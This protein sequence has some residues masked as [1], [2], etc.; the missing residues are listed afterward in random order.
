M[1]PLVSLE[2]CWGQI[3]WS[4]TLVCR[5]DVLF[6]LKLKRFLVSGQIM[7]ESIQECIR[8]LLLILQCDR[9]YQVS[10]CDLNVTSHYQSMTS[11]YRLQKAVVGDCLCILTE[12]SSHVRWLTFHSNCTCLDLPYGFNHLTTDFFR[13]PFMTKIFM[14]VFYSNRAL[15]SLT[16]YIQPWTTRDFVTLQMVTPSVGVVHWRL[17]FHLA[18]PTATRFQRSSTCEILP[19]WTKNIATLT[20]DIDVW[21]AK[22]CV[23]LLRLCSMEW[24][25]LLLYRQGV[26][27]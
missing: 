10:F 8:G 27:L 23:L 20:C 17:R 19:L 25:N 12:V 22:E 24:R 7:T 14:F 15:S 11:N 1:A 5:I 2:S 26:L 6:A 3:P 9:T 13:P 21:L 4:W 16:G 18:L